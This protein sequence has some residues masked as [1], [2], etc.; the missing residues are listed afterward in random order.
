MFTVVKALVIIIKTT[1][2]KNE[3]TKHNGLRIN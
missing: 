1:V 3:D 2:K